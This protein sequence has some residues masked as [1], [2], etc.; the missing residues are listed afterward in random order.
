LPGKKTNNKTLPDNGLQLTKCGG[1]A[2]VGKRKVKNAPTGTGGGESGCEKEGKLSSSRME[3][4][5]RGRPA[6]CY[7]VNLNLKKGSPRP[8]EERGTLYL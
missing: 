1:E 8:P 4:S 2:E 7:K 5:G 3:P 6:L